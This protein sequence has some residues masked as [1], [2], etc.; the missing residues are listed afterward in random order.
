MGA[1]WV[2][3]EVGRVSVPTLQKNATLADPRALAK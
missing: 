3:T 1:G 2:V